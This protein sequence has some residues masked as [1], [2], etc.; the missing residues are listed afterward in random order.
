MSADTAGADDQLLGAAEKT[1][2]GGKSSWCQP[3]PH[4]VP[5]FP[6]RQKPKEQAILH[7]ERTVRG[8][9]IPRF[10]PAYPPAH[11]YRRRAQGSRKR[12]A[13]EAVEDASSRKAK[14]D[15]VRSVAASL[16]KIEDVA[17]ASATSSSSS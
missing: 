12:L 6:V 8:P 4:V 15:A 17:D 10:L 2:G 7:D 3:F 9:H 5:P 11:T 14:L 13:S 1:S 16:A